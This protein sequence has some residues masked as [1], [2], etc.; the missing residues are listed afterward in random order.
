MHEKMNLSAHEKLRERKIQSDQEATMSNAYRSF[1]TVPI[2][3]P[4]AFFALCVLTALILSP[5]QRA[6]ADPVDDLRRAV[7]A[8]DYAGVQTALAAG[9]DIDA[10]IEDKRGRSALIMAAESGDAQMVRLLLEAGANIEFTTKRGRHALHRALYGNAETMKVLL[11][12]GADVNAPDKRD[13]RPINI[14]VSEENMQEMVKLLIDAGADVNARNDKNNTPLHHAAE[15]GNIEA[16]Q[17]L[18]AAGAEVNAKNKKGRTPRRV[19]QKRGLT[20]AAEVIK[21]A[22]GKR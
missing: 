12:A 10:R 19:A 3:G 5:V 13:N 2:G 21:Q 15:K 14:A 20:E 1:F 17:L 18:I 9:A 6:D 11:E 8:S 4:R 16:I 22:G 7:E